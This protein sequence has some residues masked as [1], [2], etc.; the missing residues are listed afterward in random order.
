MLVALVT[1]LVLSQAQAGDLGYRYK[2]GKCVNS[3]GKEGL[4]TSYLGQCADFRLTGLGNLTLDEVD[5]SGSR[6]DGAKL[7]RSSFR[8]AILD[9]VSFERTSLSG[10]DLTEAKIRGTNFTGTVLKNV[11]FSEAQ[12]ESPIFDEAS[13]AGGTYSFFT[14][15]NCSF[16]K[17]N[18]EGAMLDNVDLE[19][20]DL[21][22]ANLTSSNLRSAN[23]TRTLLVGAT[24]HRAELIQTIL[25][26]AKVSKA[27][28][29][30]AKFNQADLRDA[31]LDQSDLRGAMIQDCKTDNTSFKETVINK[32]TQIPF[33]ESEA[34]ALGMIMGK[35]EGFAE[36]NGRSYHKIQVA[37]VMSDANILMAC[38]AEG[39]EAPCINAPGGEFSDDKCADVDWREG[40]SPMLTLSQSI[41]AGQSPS[42]CPL[43]EDVF[44]YMAGKFDGGCGV[45]GGSWCSQGSQYSD[46]YA[47]CVEL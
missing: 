37:G 21:S 23:L 8:G 46:K 20:S 44:Q 11:N 9:G 27:D 6:F 42:G 24:L 28:L 39:L 38:K 19:G 31:V 10:V 14:C 45:I 5:F 22:G 18:F 12:L 3:E 47:L 29:R 4:N 13:F 16:K 35:L 7:D 41:C 25:K 1:S 15:Q 33:S 32:K 2:E 34:T 17:T 36:L 26:S 43:L 30:K 40:G